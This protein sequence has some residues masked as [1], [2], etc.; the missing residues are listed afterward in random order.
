MFIF[1]H[2][3]CTATHFRAGFPSIFIFSDKWAETSGHFSFVLWMIIEARQ[4]FK[5]V[6]GNLFQV[7][8]ANTN[9]EKY[10]ECNN[11]VGHRYVKLSH[12]KYK[13]Y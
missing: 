2:S 5:L 10:Y 7:G 1:M 13:S 12:Y 3:C 11:P 8:P 6:N 4:R 9:L